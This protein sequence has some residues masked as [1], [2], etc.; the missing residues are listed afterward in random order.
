MNP[1]N[2]PLE[3]KDYGVR[4][5]YL[6]LKDVT[7]TKLSDDPAEIDIS[8]E[9]MPQWHWTN[10]RSVCGGHCLE[11]APVRKRRIRKCAC[12]FMN[13]RRSTSFKDIGNVC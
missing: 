4:N 13:A 7:L 1:T 11:D 6:E 8:S 12:K 3:T 9:I 5:G 10:L 2:T